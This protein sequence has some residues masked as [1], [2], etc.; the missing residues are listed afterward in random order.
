ML[1]FD[2]ER[3]SSC[4]GQQKCIDWVEIDY[5]NYG[6]AQR[7]CGVGEEGQIHVDGSSELMIEFVSNREQE[8]VGFLYFAICSEPDF[9][10]NAVKFG[11]EESESRMKRAVAQCTSPSRPR[12]S[13]DF[14]VSFGVVYEV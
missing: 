7:F 1:E 3:D 8:N 4:S 6:T 11:I 12:T 10:Q 2:V 5:V 13:D 14:I 9:D